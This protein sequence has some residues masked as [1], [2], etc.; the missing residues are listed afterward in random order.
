MY[1]F[2]RILNQTLFSNNVNSN[3]PLLNFKNRVRII[4]L[5]LMFIVFSANAQIT[6]FAFRDY[7]GNGTQQAGEPGR[8]GIIV[9]FYSNT[10]LPGK[11]AYLGSTTTNASGSYSYTPAV[12]PVRIEF[13]IPSGL[14]NISPT[15]DYSGAFGTGYGTAVQFAYGP[16]VH[17]FVV[18]YPSD[19]STDANPY[20]FLTIF[21]NGDPL[22]TSGTAKNLPGVI[23]FR[24]KNSGYALNS[25]RGGNTGNAYD[26]CAKQSQVGSTWGMAI[27]RQAKKVWVSATVRRHAGIG[28]LGSGGIYWFDSEGPFNLNANLK[29]IDFDSD[30]GIPTSD[31]V[32]PYTKALTGSCSNEVFFSP[33]LGSNTDRILPGNPANP[34]A[35]PAAWDQVGKLSFGDLDIS[36]DGRYLYVVNLYDRKL[37]EIDLQD[38]FNPQIPTSAEV[39]SY[40]IPSPCG[41]DNTPSGQH[42]P[43]GLK[44]SRGK[45][46]VGVVCSASNDNGT[47]TG[48][49]AGDMTGNI[50]EFDVATQTWN[51]TPLVD[52]TMDYRNGDKPWLPWRRKWWS[53]GYEVNGT[54]MITDIEF[55]ANGNF[56]IGVTDRHGSQTGHQNADLCGNCCND[57]NAMVGEML[58]AVRD[59]NSATCSYSIKFSPEYYKDNYIHTESTMGALSVHFTAEFDGALTT[60]MDPIGIYSSGVML[61][62][63]RTG[64]RQATT[65]R[66]GGSTEG[67][68]VVY[69]TSGNNGPFGKANSLGDVETVEIVPPI[70]IG[71]LVW[72]DTDKDGVQDG[73]EPG[74]AGVTIELLDINGNLVAST[75]TNVNGGYYF[76]YT[77]V[78]DTI[79]PTKD[80][81]LGPQKLTDYMLRISP[82]QFSGGVGLG[83]IAAYT[84]TGTNQSGTGITDYSDNDASLVGGQAKFNIKTKGPGEND[85]TFDFGLIGCPKPICEPVTNTKN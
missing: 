38:P 82:T 50:F 57:N 28:P 45:V 22:N 25:G 33:V 13:E 2:S 83:V 7:N 17:N 66:V 67:Y 78:V 14:C 40:I 71:N 37:Y 68:E 9:K 16:S 36:E 18:S 80:N 44:I 11:D 12:Y 51:N 24:Y 77:N 21:G 52:W 23:R 85:H 55:D 47:P 84:L 27:S 6:G 70:E 79:G 56:L 30:L 3:A 59:P 5:F 34:N 31:Q 74:I 15:Q 26:T 64:A 46:Y 61:Y 29:F 35:D 39:K 41:G 8:G 76:N 20:S 48:G 73:D 65:N 53:D 1:T 4:T 54:P 42:R 69:S 62:D 81:V 63:N 19:F 75:V 43:F 60:F 32:N 58:Q 49:D 10:A 72:L